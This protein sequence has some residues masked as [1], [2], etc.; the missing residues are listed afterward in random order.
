MKKPYKIYS[1]TSGFSYIN[2]KGK[3]KDALQ[4]YASKLNFVEINSSFYKIPS[5]E[6]FNKWKNEVPE[7]FKF[8]I[9]VN[10][11]FTHTKKLKIDE[12]FIQRWQTFLENC[13]ILKSKL[14]PLL[15]QL[16]P[17]LK[18]STEGKTAMLDKL[19]ALSKLIP[20]SQAVVFECRDNSWDS[21][22]ALDTLKKLGWSYCVVHSKNIDE[23]L[24]NIE[25]GYFPKNKDAW[26]LGDWG[27][28]FR[29]HGSEGQYVGSYPKKILDI[30][31]DWIKEHEMRLKQQKGHK[32]K[33]PQEY[34][35]SFNNTDSI[36]N[37]AEHLLSATKDA[38]RVKEMAG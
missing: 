10:R 36:E 13:Q 24:G 17:R 20:K 19:K 6:T 29:F 5:P 26:A 30:V 23:F 25:S 12:N 21:I 8:T 16:P 2:P 1:G 18:F 7:N 33:K 9:K 38:L 4:L 15:F 28:Y 37:D 31:F 27:A 3:H 14:G 11:Y 32:A 22:E 34:Y 35:F